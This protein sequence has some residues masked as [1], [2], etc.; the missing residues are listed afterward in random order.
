M[1]LNK[2]QMQI[3]RQ[4]KM[5]KHG[6]LSAPEYP[7]N[8]PEGCKWLGGEGYG[9][10]FHISKPQNLKKNEFRIRRYSSKGKLH[11]DRI[12]IIDAY[13]KFNIRQEY[14][15]AYISHCEQCVIIQK[16]E[17][18]IFKSITLD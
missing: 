1:S 10:W 4:N 3:I 7:D 12:F 17:I 8:L 15:F 6:A 14:E 11:C 5:M 9:V 13:R 18:L 2:N 16:G